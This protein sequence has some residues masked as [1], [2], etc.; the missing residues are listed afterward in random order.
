MNEQLTRESA[1]KRSPVGLC[2][3]L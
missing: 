2:R 3:H 1:W